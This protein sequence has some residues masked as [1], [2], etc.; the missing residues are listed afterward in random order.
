MVRLRKNAKIE[1][2][3]R[4][5]LFSGC[6]KAE[7]SRIAAIADE[8]HQPPGSELIREGTRG[9]EFCVMVSGAVSVHSKGVELRALTAGDF[10][11][12]IALIMDVRRSATVTATTPVRLLV[13]ERLAFQRLLRDQPSI[14]A[15]ILRELAGRL[16]A[17]S[18]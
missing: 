1:L 8:I 13:L 18:L 9:S 6:S 7:L 2:I 15:K 10:F 12:E 14:Q 17:E 16:A 11:G 5:P 3:S 4:L